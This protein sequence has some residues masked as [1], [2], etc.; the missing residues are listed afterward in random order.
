MEPD[1][2]RLLTT[3]AAHPSLDRASAYL[4]SSAVRIIQRLDRLEERLACALFTRHGRVLQLTAAGAVRLSHVD[5]GSDPVPRYTPDPSLSGNIRIAATRALGEND[6]LR[7][8]A[9]FLAAHPG[10]QVELC[11]EDRQLDLDAE[12]LDLAFV[13]GRGNAPSTEGE[14]L[15]ALWTYHVASPGWLRQNIAPRTITDWASVRRIGGLVTDRWPDAPPGGPTPPLA[16]RV[17]SPEAA[18]RAALAGVGVACVPAPLCSG[19]LRRGNLVLLRDGE[20]AGQTELFAVQPRRRAP[21][22]LARAVIHHVRQ[23][24]TP[25]ARPQA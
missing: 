2:L 9:T 14:Q 6:A 13:I 4:G 24:L 16:L 23:G 10:V 18:V 17:D 7:Y 25:W 20:P 1:D 21:N 3:L 19:H 8:T 15:A 5:V 11:L 12:N 22:P